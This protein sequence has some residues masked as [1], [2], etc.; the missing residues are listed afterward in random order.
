M[1]KKIIFLVLACLLLGAILTY[2]FF[3]GT[4]NTVGSSIEKN[5]GNSIAYLSE[6]NQKQVIKVFN[7]NQEKFTKVLQIKQERDPYSTSYYNQKEKKTVVV[8]QQMLPYGYQV[9]LQNPSDIQNLGLLEERVHEVIFN[10]EYLYALVYADD[11]SVYLKK[12]NLKNL[13]KPL[14]AWKLE[15]DP[16][17]LI[18]DEDSDKIYILMRTNKTIL[19][20]L[21]NGETLKQKEILEQGYDLNAT[22]EEEKL[23]ILPREILDNIKVK[24]KKNKEVKYIYCVNLP[25][26]EIN[27]KIPTK[28]PPKFIQVDKEKIY[29]ITGTPNESFLEIYNRQTYENEKILE[30]HLNTIYGFVNMK[31]ENYIFANNGIFKV[32]QNHLE[33]VLKED[34]SS[35]TDFVIR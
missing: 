5:S 12:F 32:K 6:D 25:N 2:F 23:W 34:I 4:K 35:N 15:G 14:K 29:V 20:S 18:L 3:T 21:E 7:F 10:K 33:K 17:R 1:K 22:I 8:T 28:Y 27:S 13:D 9:Y 24:S 19:Y 31:N 11:N 30:L 26:L 16:E